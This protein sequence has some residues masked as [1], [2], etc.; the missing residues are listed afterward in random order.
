VPVQVVPLPKG[1]VTYTHEFE[2]RMIAKDLGYRYE[3]FRDLPLDDQAGHIA[4]WRD[5]KRLEAVIAHKSK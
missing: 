4:F 2:L 5:E 1:E 3:D